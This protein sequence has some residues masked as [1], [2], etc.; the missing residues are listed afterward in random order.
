MTNTWAFLLSFLKTINK[1]K[2]NPSKK[3][4]INHEIEVIMIIIFKF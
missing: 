2:K 4:Q 3:N 1:E